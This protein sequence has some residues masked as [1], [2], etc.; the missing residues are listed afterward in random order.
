MWSS[1]GYLLISSTQHL[2]S[3]YL[4]LTII[5]LTFI[6]SPVYSKSFIL[7][8]SNYLTSYILSVN[9]SPCINIFDYS[10][11]LII[12]SPHLHL[13]LSSVFHATNLIF[14]ILIYFQQWTHILIDHHRVTTAKDFNSSYEDSSNDE[15]SRKPWT[16]LIQGLLH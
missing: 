1:S 14:L 10:L 6:I 3:P 8:L 12:I 5:D 7:S 13:Y 9:S 16:A 2:L 11:S 15:D 4:I